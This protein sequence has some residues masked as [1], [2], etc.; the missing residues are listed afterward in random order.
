ML[1]MVERQ[2]N[3]RVGDYMEGIPDLRMY[4][5]GNDEETGLFGRLAQG[6]QRNWARYE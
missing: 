2:P 3:Q 5:K 4:F 1:F 6:Y